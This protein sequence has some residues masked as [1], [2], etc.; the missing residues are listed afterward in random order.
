MIFGI[1]KPNYKIIDT[2]KIFM[3]V[4]KNHGHDSFVFT[5]KDV[6]FTH[7]NILGK[8]IWKGK[9]IEKSF[10][11]PNIIQNRLPINEV[12][13]STYVKLAKEIPFT[14]HHIETK[15]ELYLKMIKHPLM[16]KYMIES[17]SCRSFQILMD[18]IER[19]QYV[20][21]KPASSKQAI[22]ICTIQKDN[23]EFIVKDL[24]QVLELDFNELKLF[25]EQK[26]L[27]EQ[28]YIS[29]FFHSA[30]INQLSTV[31]RL[32]MILGEDGKWQKI[33][34]FPY[35]NLNEDQDIANGIQG[36]LISTRE[37]LFLKQ[38]YPQVYQDILT[39]IDLLFDD[40]AQFMQ[41]NYKYS[42]DA[43]GIDIGINQRGEIKIFEINA[44][45][46]VGFMAYPVAEQ[47][48]LYYE[49]V[50]N[51]DVIEKTDKFLPRRYRHYYHQD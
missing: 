45:P 48:V 25:F 15:F 32:H 34:F 23:D 26:K 38:Y 47:Q 9:I 35:V 44:G 17:E 5:A 31:F 29:P 11:F 7:K 8:T 20:I 36:A 46:G 39:N 42:I 4:A 40:T 37:E 49:W 16:Q 50:L 3:T 18:F 1:L 13:I 6:D 21:L 30:T 22:G 19:Y 27:K 28:L 12:D 43:I 33:K 10:S 24:N 51:Q 2:E 41:D 14:T